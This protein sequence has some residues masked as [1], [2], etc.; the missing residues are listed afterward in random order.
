MGDPLYWV[1]FLVGTG[2]LALLGWLGRRYVVVRRL[3]AG[4]TEAI[5]DRK[6][7]AIGEETGE[8]AI[9]LRAL[10][11]R[12]AAEMIERDLTSQFD[13]HLADAG[14]NPDG[15]PL[16]DKIRG[17]RDIGDAPTPPPEPLVGLDE[18]MAGPDTEA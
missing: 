13:R 18:M 12:I 2:L 9:A 15:S 1:G 17:V 8:H 4:V 10:T 7:A 5:S 16:R 6:D 3:L 11:T 14:H